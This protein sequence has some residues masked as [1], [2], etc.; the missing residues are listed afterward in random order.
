LCRRL[1]F[2]TDHQNLGVSRMGEARPAFAPVPA[3][4][5]I[6]GMTRSGTYEAIAAGHLHAV[7]QGRKTLIDCDHGLAWLR[8]LPAAKVTPRKSEP[9]TA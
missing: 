2:S 6:S 7:K 1:I 9:V 8:A 3:W 4:C 5:D